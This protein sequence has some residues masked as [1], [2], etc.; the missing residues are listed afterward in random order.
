M[1]SQTSLGEKILQYQKG[2]GSSNFAGPPQMQAFPDTSFPVGTGSTP[3]PGSTLQANTHQGPRF[4]TTLNSA[5]HMPNG[6]APSNTNIQQSPNAYDGPT[7]GASSPG[8][9]PQTPQQ[10]AALRQR[11]AQMVENLGRNIYQQQLAAGIVGTGAVNGTRLPALQ[12]HNSPT[13]SHTL[14]PGDGVQRQHGPSYPQANLFHQNYQES[15]AATGTQMYPESAHPSF[16]L[17]SAPSSMSTHQFDAGIPPASMSHE[18]PLLPGIRADYENMRRSFSATANLTPQPSSDGPH[19]IA[20]AEPRKRSMAPSSPAVT[21]R[22]RPRLSLP[23]EDDVPRL[24]PS[25]SNHESYMPAGVSAEVSDN[26]ISHDAASE[27]SEGQ[28]KY[29]MA[30]C[31]A[32]LGEQSFLNVPNSL[33]SQY[34]LV[35]MGAPRGVVPIDPQLFSTGPA[36]PEAQAGNFTDLRRDS[37]GADATPVDPQLYKHNVDP[38]TV[39]PIQDNLLDVGGQVAEQ[40]NFPQPQDFQSAGEWNGWDS[41]SEPDWSLLQDGV[42]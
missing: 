17:G 3:Q 34:G 18:S 23:G 15:M 4:D 32:T 7:V 2:T 36:A 28:Y 16:S 1:R 29:S 13:T 31:S 5:R 21:S 39:Q 38:H 41:S 37:L 12:H 14:S 25:S 33:G 11:A 42:F 30:P 26:L 19:N 24:A 6:S 40:T 20:F 9:S 35:D 10:E 8:F 22:K 27:H